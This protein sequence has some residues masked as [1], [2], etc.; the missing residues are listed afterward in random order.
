MDRNALLELSDER[1]QWER[2]CLAAYR[3]GWNASERAHADDYGTGYYDGILD[4]KRFEHQLVEEAE[5]EL[6]RWGLNG[7]ERFGDPRPGDWPGAPEG[8]AKVRA[9]WLSQGLDLGPGPGWVHLGGAPV[10]WHKALHPGVLRIPAGLA[11]HRGRHRVLLQ[12]LS[13][14]QCQ[15]AQPFLVQVGRSAPYLGVCGSLGDRL[16]AGKVG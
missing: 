1:D 13:G 16:A 12:Q 4:R 8:L 7:P 3:E 14:P 5:L 6:L 2:L 11:P 15:V 10:H 9:S